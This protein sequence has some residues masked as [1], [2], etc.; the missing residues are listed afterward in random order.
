[1]N[2]KYIQ[3]T[4]LI[5]FPGQIASTIFVG[6][7]N[8][9]CD[10]CYNQALLEKHHEIPNVSEEK[11]ISLLENRKKFI[12]GIAITGGEPTVQKRLIPFIKE[13]KK[14]G[15]QVKLDTNGYRPDVLQE[16]INQDL[17]DYIAMD[18]KAPLSKYSDIARVEINSN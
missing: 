17:V 7:C 14:I 11:I 12:D 2:I 8:F 9:N 1:M 16:I 5:D 10:F 15:F 3:K 6:G 18:I 4:T 13:I